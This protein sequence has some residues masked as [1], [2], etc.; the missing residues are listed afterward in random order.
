MSSNNWADEMSQGGIF[1]D[2]PAMSGFA[3]ANLG[4][5]PRRVLLLLRR[6]RFVSPLTAPRAPR[7]SL[8]EGAARRAV[9]QQQLAAPLS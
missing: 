7:S 1:D 6:W 2:N 5:R 9:R 8:C 3:D 4:T